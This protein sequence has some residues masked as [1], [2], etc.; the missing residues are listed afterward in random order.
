MDISS[1]DGEGND[2]TPRRDVISDTKDVIQGLDALKVE[3]K[4]VS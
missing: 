4:Q 1:S 2:R 3:Y